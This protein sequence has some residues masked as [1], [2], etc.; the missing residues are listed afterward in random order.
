MISSAMRMQ[1]GA[2]PRRAAPRAHPERRVTA[3]A[4][5]AWQSWDQYMTKRS[6]VRKP[7]KEELKLFD[8]IGSAI[9]TS[10]ATFKPKFI[11]GAASEAGYK[12]VH[13]DKVPKAVPLSPDLH[14]KLEAMAM[15]QIREALGLPE[16]APLDVATTSASTT[17]INAGVCIS[18]FVTQDGAY[19]KAVLAVVVAETEREASWSRLEGL[20]LHW[21]CASAP[22]SGWHMPPV[23]WKAIRPTKSRDAGGAV[24]CSFDKYS[25]PGGASKV[26][27]LV[28][29]LPLSGI[30]RSGGITFVLKASEAQNTKWLKEAASER[31][32]FVDL[33]S[34]PFYKV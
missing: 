5:T 4:A 12:Q 17:D 34:L 2:A 22:G 10:A 23:G 33:Q 13:V 26:Y 1:S 9:N 16:D 15:I 30:L 21:A 19:K 27:A 7:V 31:D 25:V 14:E 18:G 8:E 3:N 6:D 11:A 29:E 32:F 28:M 24:Q 20:L